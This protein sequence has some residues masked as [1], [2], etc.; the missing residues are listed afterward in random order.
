MPCYEMFYIMRK[1]EK[2]IAQYVWKYIVMI[3][4]RF[5]KDFAAVMWMVCICS[6]MNPAAE[7]MMSYVSYMEN[8]MLAYFYLYSFSYKDWENIQSCV[9][10]FSFIFI[11][12][13]LLRLYFSQLKAFC[14]L[15]GAL[16]YQP[17]ATGNEQCRYKKEKSK[18]QR[19]SKYHI[20]RLRSNQIYPHP[21]QS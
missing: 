11:R 8:K 10:I 4:A 2:Q 19:N 9:V 3:Q 15:P 14:I 16:G 13:Q 12:R 18:E 5:L 21:I 1:S 7:L 6:P 20:R 17:Y